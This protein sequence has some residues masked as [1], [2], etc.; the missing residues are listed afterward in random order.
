MED[1]EK[2]TGISG[3]RRMTRSA[4]YRYLY[5]AKGFCS[6]QQLARDLELS[7]PTVYQNLTELMD[8]GLVQFSGEQ[9]STGGRKASGLSIVP[10]A[11]VAV[12]VSITDRHLR[13]AAADLRM[14]ELGYRK[15]AT[16]PIDA[17]SS[18]LCRELEH[19][20]DEFSIDRERLL[21]VGIA[22]PAII[23]HEN[24]FLRYAPTLSLRDV[25]LESLTKHIPYPTFVENDANSGGYIEWFSRRSDKSMAYF[26]LENGVGGAV[27]M[28]G[29]P[30]LGENRRGGEFG[31]MCVEPCGLRCTCGKQGCLEAYC[32]ARRI[33]DD[34]GITLDE[35]FAG[36]ER[37]VPEYVYLWHDVLRH[38]AI[39][40]SNIRM[41]LDCNIVLGGLLTEYLPPYMDILKRYVTALDSFSADADYVHLSALPRNTVPLGAALHFIDQFLK[42]L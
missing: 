22:L 41:A 25:S 5:E 24:R 1:M 11:R 37:E 18:S 4:I 13:L 23:D 32:S 21:G 40:I 9:Q 31:H 27:L 15:T 39:G 14:R 30:W 35:F 42:T 19:F 29:A 36:L 17:L 10:D 38:L 2:N 20:L 16:G 26:S 7:L 8:M 33:S 12:G 34:L 6:R 3:R 28:N